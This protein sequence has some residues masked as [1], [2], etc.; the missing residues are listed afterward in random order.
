MPPEAPTVVS[1]DAF[2][3]CWSAGFLGRPPISN[4]SVLC[5]SKSNGACSKKPAEFNSEVPAINFTR[6]NQ[7]GRVFCANVSGPSAD[8]TCTIGANN[9]AF[10]VSTP[11][12]VS[13]KPGS[14]NGPHIILTMIV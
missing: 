2:D 1:S 5:T 9:G 7:I 6:V 14:R 13:T 12:D 11:A 8:Y 10:D 4:F 3:I